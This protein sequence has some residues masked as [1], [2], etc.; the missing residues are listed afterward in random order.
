M[1]RITGDTIDISE[2]TNFG[3]YELLQ[4]WDKQESEE[5]P[6]IGRWFGLSCILVS[7]LCYYILTVK[8]KF[9]ARKTVQH[10]KNDEVTTD[11]LQRSI[12]HY[13][14]CLAESFGQVDHYNNNLDGIEGFT[15]NDAPKPYET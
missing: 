8:G 15:N 3:Y 11:Y 13:S 7:V 9:I 4:Y 2:W 10:V 1:E 6:M 14:K 12:G 5:N